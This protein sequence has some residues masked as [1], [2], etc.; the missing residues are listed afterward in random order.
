MGKV[1][2]EQLEKGALA[3]LPLTSLTGKHCQDWGKLDVLLGCL[4]EKHCR[5]RVKLDVLRGCH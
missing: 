3:Q 5:D 1:V 2:S 4:A